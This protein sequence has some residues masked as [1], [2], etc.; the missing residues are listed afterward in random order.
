MPLTRELPESFKNRVVVFDGAMGSLLVERG[1]NHVHPFEEI[2]PLRAVY[3]LPGPRGLYQGR[4]GRHRNQH[5][6]R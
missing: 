1:V 4:G 2:Q 6:R 5:I 3:G